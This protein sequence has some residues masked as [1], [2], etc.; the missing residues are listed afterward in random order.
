[1]DDLPKEL[2]LAAF[3]GAAIRQNTTANILACNEQTAPYGLTL[4][5]Q[6]AAA[7][8]E[9]QALSLKRAGRIEFGGG[10]AQQLILAFCDSPYLDAQSY[11][12]TLHE[13]TEGFYEFKND[14]CD[15]LSDTALLRVMRQAFDGVCRG[16]VE[17]LLGTVLPALARHIRAGGTLREFLSV[18]DMSGDAP[19]DSETDGG[20]DSDE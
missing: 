18:Y 2:T 10:I 6:A 9:T 8:A 3:C 1:M 11:E 7:L 14:T 20:D 4:T 5:P 13:L 16:S 17:Q 12:Q 15:V 19:A